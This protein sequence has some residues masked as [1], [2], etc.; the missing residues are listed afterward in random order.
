MDELI[1]RAKQGDA[2]ATEEIINNYMPL[3]INQACKYK[4]AGY[5]YEDLVQHSI[6]SVIQAIQLYEIKHT[7]FASFVAKVVKNN[8]INLL[9]SKMKHN[10]EV[11]SEEV[12]KDSLS[13]YYFTL[14]DEVIAYDMVKSL[15]EAI[16]KLEHKDRKVLVDY[17]FKRKQ[18]KIIAEE[19]GLTY[20]QTH[21]LKK[22]ALINI[23]KLL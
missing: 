18:L 22:N 1:I 4:I 5:E 15:N 13:N 21:S 7:S 23:K 6:L 16:N 12:I 10:R 11:Q 14:E 9:L 19:L 2:S 17:Y 8:N 20:S 3:V